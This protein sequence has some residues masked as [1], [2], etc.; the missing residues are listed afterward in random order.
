MDPQNKSC[1]QL[2]QQWQSGL[3]PSSLLNEWKN[4]VN[5][6]DR[7][8]NIL[9]KDLPLQERQQKMN[10][11]CCELVMQCNN[12]NDWLQKNNINFACPVQKQPDYPHFGDLKP[13][14]NNKNNHWAGVF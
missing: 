12:P 7:D 5:S 11:E 8:K 1:D 4:C 9:W 6:P 13:V 14:S 2:D 3:M 10:L